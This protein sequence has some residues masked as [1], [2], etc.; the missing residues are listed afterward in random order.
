MIIFDREGLYLG[1]KFGISSRGSFIIF[2]KSC[3]SLNI[4]LIYLILFLEVLDIYSVF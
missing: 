4:N 3:L 2:N 1:M